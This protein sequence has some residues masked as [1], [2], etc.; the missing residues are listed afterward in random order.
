M[1]GP[2]YVPG[3]L[4]VP[5]SDSLNVHCNCSAGRF[6]VCNALTRYTLRATCMPRTRHRYSI[7][8]VHGCAAHR[9]K[10]VCLR[11]ENARFQSFQKTCAHMSIACPVTKVQRAAH[12]DN[13]MMR[14]HPPCAP[15][16]RF[17]IAQAHEI[18]M[19]MRC[20]S[21]RSSAANC[22][23]HTPVLYLIHSVLWC[24]FVARRGQ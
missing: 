6:R 18:D 1:H 5:R 10:R 23:H 15:E 16:H 3:P 21:V 8:C 11:F 13:D 9:E 24:W 4:S 22:V 14:M 17:K 7:R 19:K 20:S 2:L 12:N